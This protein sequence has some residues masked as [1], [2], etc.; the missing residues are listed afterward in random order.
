VVF[1]DDTG[2]VGGAVASDGC[3][4][5]DTS[6]ANSLD[7][8]RCMMRFQTINIAKKLL[9]LTQ[10][11]YMTQSHEI[12]GLREVVRGLHEVLEAM[13]ESNTAILDMLHELEDEMEAEEELQN[14]QNKEK[15]KTNGS[16]QD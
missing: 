13:E 7:T 15:D 2:R 10:R 3:M 14:T 8:L 12:E 6:L 1:L 9:R 16:N 5:R 4:Y 11:F